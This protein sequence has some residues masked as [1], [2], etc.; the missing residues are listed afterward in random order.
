MLSAQFALPLPQPHTNTKSFPWCAHT[1]IWKH[2]IQSIKSGHSVPSRVWTLYYKLRLTAAAFFSFFF[3]WWPISC[4][5]CQSIITLS[6]NFFSYF[7]TFFSPNSHLTSVTTSDF[8]NLK[9]SKQ[10]IFYII[11]WNV[12]LFTLK[13]LSIRI[14]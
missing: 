3:I 5:F 11:V 13:F 12:S 10:K 1:L 14:F 6:I 2:A 8:F 7:W 4:C 9:F